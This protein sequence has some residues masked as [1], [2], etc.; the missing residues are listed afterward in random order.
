MAKKTTGM[1]MAGCC[2]V[3]AVVSV[4][5]RGQTILPKELRNKHNIKA[6][7]KLAVI[8]VNCCQDSSCVVLIKVDRLSG[9]LKEILGP[10]MDELKKS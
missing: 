6:G 8:S 1:N 10:A 2:K 9:M 3:E 5:E 4:D 7:D